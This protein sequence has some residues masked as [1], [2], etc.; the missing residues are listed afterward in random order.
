MGLKAPL[1]LGEGAADQERKRKRLLKEQEKRRKEA[2]GQGPSLYE[3]HQAKAGVREKEDDPSAR[4]FDREKDIAG[5]VKI[6]HGKRQELLRNAKGFGGRFEGGG[7][8]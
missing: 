4:A 6:G 7:V 2:G 3:T 8:L 5:G 1:V